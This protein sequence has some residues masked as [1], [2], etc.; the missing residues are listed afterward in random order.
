MKKTCIVVDDQKSHQLLLSQ[1]AEICGLD[2][3]G[4]GENGKDAIELF[5]KSAPDIVFLDMRMPEYD[6]FYAI[7]GIQNIDDSAK[8]IVVTADST[9]DTFDKLINSS[10]HII[11]K[12]YTLD[13]LQ[14]T[15]KELK[16][17]E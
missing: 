3:I 1:M 6:G 11:A 17:D 14:K 8:I 2:V 15:L 7:N 12:P 5:E 16:F 10:V 4:V 9:G 13:I